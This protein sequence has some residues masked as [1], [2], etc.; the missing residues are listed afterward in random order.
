MPRNLPPRFQSHIARAHRTR[1]IGNALVTCLLV[2]T[3]A[4]LTQ[5]RN[6]PTKPLQLCKRSPQISATPSANFPPTNS[7]PQQHPS[8]N[9]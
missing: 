6:F 9:P 2:G 7:Q 1:I 3:G 8:R 4:A 5:T